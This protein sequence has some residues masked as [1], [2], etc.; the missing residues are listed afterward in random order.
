VAKWI[1][2][3]LLCYLF[4]ILGLRSCYIRED[5]HSS[6]QSPNKNVG[7]TSW[8]KFRMF[9]SKVALFIIH[10][11]LSVW[12]LKTYT[13]GN[14]SI[15]IWKKFWVDQCNRCSRVV[16]RQAVY[17]NVIY[18]LYNITLISDFYSPTNAQVIVLKTIL[19]FTLK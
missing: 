18:I 12:F 5:F 4:L 9:S 1:E 14:Q 17:F 19:K 3:L 7:V 11:V 15:N 10:S 2:I 13:D 8:N 16:S 6:S